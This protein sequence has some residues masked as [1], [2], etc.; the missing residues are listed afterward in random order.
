MSKLKERFP[1]LVDTSA[2]LEVVDGIIDAV[3]GDGGRINT[4]DLVEAIKNKV[5]DLDIVE[6]RIIEEGRKS[7]AEQIA[8]AW[9]NIHTIRLDR[10]RRVPTYQSQFG[11]AESYFKVGSWFVPSGAMTAADFEYM[12][13]K[14]ASRIT[15]A[16][17][18]HT[19]WQ[20]FFE[21]VRPGL[22]RG[23]T[24]VQLFDSGELELAAVNGAPAIEEGGD[25][26]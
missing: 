11:F 22:E 6:E 5:A 19:I 14:Q 23:E 20:E 21:R 13:E 24:L 8:S 15:N 3:A 17:T 16:Q 10:N 9:A 1:T 18:D 7:A 12:L 26:S 2:K 25:E 4:P